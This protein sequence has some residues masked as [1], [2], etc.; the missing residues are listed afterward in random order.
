MAVYV[1]L[2]A[3]VAAD[4]AQGQAGDASTLLVDG[5]HVTLMAGRLWVRLGD[6]H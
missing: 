1:P 4:R 3:G 6:K 2:G 5:K